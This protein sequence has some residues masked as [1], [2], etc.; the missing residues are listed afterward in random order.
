MTRSN[1]SLR[2]AFAANPTRFLAVPAPRPTAVSRFPTEAH[3][4]RSV[5]LS[6]PSTAASHPLGERLHQLGLHGM[7]RG[8]GQFEADD[9]AQAATS[10]WLSRLI[11]DEVA[12]RRQQRV[13]RRLRAA[14]LRCQAALAEVDYNA[15]RG[16]DDG[17][18]HWLA[19]GRWIGDKENLI[20]DGPTGVGKTWLACALGEQACRDDRAVLY[21]RVPD[22]LGDLDT[23]RGSV[24][25]ARRMR[26]L[27]GVELLILDDWGLEPFAADHRRDMLAIVEHRHGRAS[28]LIASQVPVENWGNLIGDPLIAAALLDRIVPGAHRL[29]LSGP[30]LR[31]RSG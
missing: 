11:E 19:I 10:E 21:E 6:S 13:A 27:Y 29:Q 18:F 16:F 2:N 23:C 12:E 31:A 5:V 3:A 17:L 9:A 7:A 20:I 22:L 1:I 25:H 15:P 30:S 26:K 28:T 8:L 14:R 4:S 24:G